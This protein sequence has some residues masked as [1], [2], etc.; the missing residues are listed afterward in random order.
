LKD[1]ESVFNLSIP[2]ET[3]EDANLSPEVYTDCKE[4]CLVVI[5]QKLDRV[6]II[7]PKA[8]KEL[9]KTLTMKFPGKNIQMNYGTFLQKAKRMMLTIQDRQSGKICTYPTK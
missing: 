6:D 7:V 8:E 5:H 4:D 9:K 1:G 2:F 3:L